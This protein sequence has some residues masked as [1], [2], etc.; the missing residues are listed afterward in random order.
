M[1][2]GTLEVNYKDQHG[3]A[4]RGTID[5]PIDLLAAGTTPPAPVT[6]APFDGYAYSVGDDSIFTFRVPDDWFQYTDI[7][8]SFD[9]YIR[10]ACNENYAANNGEVRWSA[11]FTVMRLDDEALPNGTVVTV[12]TEDIA[13]PVTAR[14]MT[15]TVIGNTEITQGASLDRHYLHVDATVG[16]TLSRVV[17]EDAAAPVQEPEIYACWIRY[18]RFK[19]W[20][21][22]IQ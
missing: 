22:S 7:N 18:T 2:T 5:I 11:T 16:V 21:R 20:G 10:W 1:V 9:L 14:Q 13:I 15:E 12:S 3:Q 8:D 17:A 6:V 19:N 4:D